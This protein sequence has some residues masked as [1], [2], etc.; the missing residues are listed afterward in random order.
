MLQTASLTVVPEPAP[1]LK[2]RKGCWTP[3]LRSQGG[4]VAAG[5]VG[6]VDEVGVNLGVVM[7]QLCTTWQALVPIGILPPQPAYSPGARRS[8]KFTMASIDHLAT[9]SLIGDPCDRY[10]N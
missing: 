3:A 5:K 6:D 10:F 7:R 4:D 9:F 1:R 2:V 8:A